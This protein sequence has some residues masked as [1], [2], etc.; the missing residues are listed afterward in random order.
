MLSEQNSWRLVASGKNV[1]LTRAILT[2]APAPK[3]EAP[4]ES[5]TEPS[6]KADAE[7]GT[8]QIALLH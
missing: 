3:P 7:R 6:A 8:Q 1:P 4:V 2:S 5:I